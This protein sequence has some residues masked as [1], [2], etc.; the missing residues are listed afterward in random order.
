[1]LYT[2]LFATA[3]T[4]LTFVILLVLA[5][6]LGS[7][8]LSQLTFFNWVAGAALG[9]LAANM[10]STTSVRQWTFG[11]YTLALFT[12]TAVVASAISLKNRTFRRVTNG[13][14]VVLIHKGEIVRSNLARA[15]MNV[16]L[17]TML[18]REKG[19]FSYQD[20]SYGILEPSGNL[21][22]LPLQET[23]SVS[24]ADLAYG[25]DLSE[26]G[27]GPYMELVVD[28]EVDHD[29]LRESGRDVEWL[30]REIRQRGGEGLADVMYLAVNVEG[31]VVA[32]LSRRKPRRA[33]G[34]GEDI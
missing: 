25:P 9:N 3:A 34:P 4:L 15:R 1:M 26:S 21:S 24:K 32:D 12:A 17:L 2:W 33:D 29:K 18:L 10:M 30:E 8:Q 23:Q 19:Y 14:P 7:T 6:W 31:D 13:E 11:L 22:I 28:G 20:I 16:D 5:R 27:Q